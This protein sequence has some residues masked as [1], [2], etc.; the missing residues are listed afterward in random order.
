MRPLSRRTL[1]RGAGTIAIALPWLEA[2]DARAA[3]LAGP[4]RR[5]VGIFQPGGT[6]R[7]RYTP[8]GTEKAFKLGPILS[9]LEPMQDRLVVIDGLDMKSAVGQQH[10]SGLIALFTG[11]TQQGGKYSAGPSLDQVIAARISEGKKAIPSLQLAV[12]WAT[13][14]SRG[15]TSPYNVLSF[16]VDAGYAPIPPRLDPVQI[17]DSLFGKLTPA[18]PGAGPDPGLVRQKSILDYVDKRYADLSARLGGG[19]RQKLEEHLGKIREIEQGLS[20]SSV[21]GGSCHAPAKVD[22]SDYSPMAGLSAAPGVFNIPTDSAIPKVGR[23]LTDMMVMALACDMTAVATFQWTDTEAKHTF[24]WLNLPEHHHYYQHD[25]GFHPDECALIGTW[26]AQQHLYLLQ[27]M[28]AVDMGGHSLLDES[29]V[30]FGSELQEPPSHNKTNMPFF[31][32]GGGGGLKTGRWLTYNSLTHNN[33][34]VSVLNLFGDERQT[35]GDP[36]YCTGPLTNFA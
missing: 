34:L 7:A 6:V 28:A 5:F 27:Q 16:E 21:V 14:K 32:A 36:R 2:M 15:L 3:P 9:P 1:L 29:V 31:L 18:A 4:A 10:Q 12:R 8:T 11:T 23:Y 33:L 24:P 30:F 17:F 25:G 19:D 26:Y 22:T 35:F 13:G 20:Q